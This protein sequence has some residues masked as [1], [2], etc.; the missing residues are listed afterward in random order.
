MGEIQIIQNNKTHSIQKK[1]SYLR[2]FSV[3]FMF[4]ILTTVIFSI[5][6]GLIIPKQISD[7][8]IRKAYA[9]TAEEYEQQLEEAERIK[10][11]K[12]RILAETRKS[13]QDITASNVSL[14][15][16]IWMIDDKLGQSNAKLEEN[17]RL[18][19]EKEAQLEEQKS[20]LEEKLLLIADVSTE[21][22]KNSRMGIME[23][24]L[25]KWNTDD[26]WSLLNYKRYAL[27]N[28]IALGKEL[29]EQV[30]EIEKQ[31]KDIENSRIQ[32]EAEKQALDDSKRA[33]EAERAMLIEQMNQTYA[34]QYQLSSE[35]S[36][37]NGQISEL[38]RA[39][40]V[41][42]SGG[43]IVNEG[44]VPNTGDYNATLAGF[45]DNA[46]SGYFGVFSIGAY[47]HRNG[48]S[49]TGAYARAEAGQSAEEILQAYY[50][51][52]VL[53]K[54]YPSMA[55]IS[56]IGY[57]DPIPFETDYLY[58]IHEMPESWG[59]EALKA[60]A[61]IARTYAIRRTSNGA[62]AICAT[63]ACQVF[64]YPLKSGAWKQAVDETRGWVLQDANGNIISTQYAAIHGGYVNNVG[65]DTT[66]RS[67]SGDWL[68]RSWESMSGHPWF[69]RS[70]YRQT[71]NDS[72]AT[73]GRNSWMSEEEMADMLN[74]WL[75]LKGSG[76][77]AGY[78][79]SRILP[80]T[81]SQCPI[82]GLG[83]NPYSMQEM[84]D[85]LV[86]PIT[87]I[88]GIPYNVQGDNAQTQYI[89]FNTNIG[90]ISVPGSE[91]KNTYNLRAPGYL[92][93]PQTGF[94]FINIDRN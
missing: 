40:I 74:T 28:Q 20:I 78:D 35:I 56:V 36:S 8:F 92:S 32:I 41:A 87:S 7:Q 42:R 82:Q 34:Q 4:V 30:A 85:L 70:W 73:C 72:S 1:M 48:M 29:N 38:Q 57:A 5:P 76:L 21:I 59:Y 51:G 43:T 55:T 61:I 91:F 13:L 89:S 15:Q 11:E 66:D 44:S 16:K 46:P 31:K 26:T 45:R 17:T 64:S 67:G 63:Q 93:I 94:T 6:S 71:Y 53:I 33:F 84:R 58:G 24:L 69:Y 83:G 80:V 54:D 3:L 12:E 81:I 14:D 49:Q 50:P 68:S 90:V 2:Y 79:S 23:I 77:K 75:V 60:Q 62:G 37:L 10:Q 18:L 19:Q 52:S 25:M 88:S 22:Y 86:N 39:I 47:T 9:T 27:K 65:W